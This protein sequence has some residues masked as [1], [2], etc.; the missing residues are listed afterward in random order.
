MSG[1]RAGRAGLAVPH[2]VVG[3]LGLVAVIVGILAMHVWMSGH[4]PTAAHG[5]HAL[6]APV[7]A[8]VEPASHHASPAPAPAPGTDPGPVHG[9]AGSCE[10]DAVAL[11]LCVLA[12]IVVTLLAFLL[13]MGRMVPGAVLLRGPPLILLRPLAIPVPCLVRLCISRT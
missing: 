1:T 5:V 7:T 8:A 11:G 4:G 3:F 10:D 6:P 13:P 12:F 9:C 2:A